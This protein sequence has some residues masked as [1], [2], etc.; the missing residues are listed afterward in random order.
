M[1]ETKKVEEYVLEV[2]IQDKVPLASM[3][4]KMS[5]SVR[6][7]PKLDAIVTGTPRKGKIMA[8][9]LKAVMTLL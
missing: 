5:T 7:Q 9:V 4:P 8:N 6:N 3:E 2:P 1:Y